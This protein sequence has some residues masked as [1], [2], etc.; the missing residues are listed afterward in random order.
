MTSILLGRKVYRILALLTLMS[1]WTS[2][3]AQFGAYERH[4]EILVNTSY[5]SASDPIYFPGNQNASPIITQHARNGSESAIIS[6]GN[7]FTELILDYTP[8]LDF[9]GMDTVVVEVTVGGIPILSNIYY[10]QFV[11][12]VLPSIVS[13]NEDY[14]TVLKGSQDNALAVLANDSSTSPGL[15]VSFLP[16]RMGGQTTV[17]NDSLF[18]TPHASFSGMAYLSYTACD[19]IGTCATEVVNIC[20]VDTVTAPVYDTIYLNTGITDPLTLFLP[21]SNFYATIVPGDGS[22]NFL[23]GTDA[24]IYTPGMNS[25]ND[26]FEVSDG[27][28]FRYYVVDVIDEYANSFVFDDHYAV[29][30]GDRIEFNVESND[31]TSNF[32]IDGFTQP[33]Y[34][35]L[36]QLNDGRFMYVADT[37]YEGITTFDY[38][39]CAI[40]NCETAT[41]EIT[42][43]RFKPVATSATHHLTGL[44]NRDLIINYDIPVGEYEFDEVVLPV[45]G[46]LTIKEG[47]DTIDQGCVTS[48]GRFMMIYT[49]DSG[50]D[51]F[52][53]FKVS[54]CSGGECN[55]VLITVE[56]LNIPVYDTCK[57]QDQ[58]VWPG[59]VDFN[60][61]VDMADLLDLGN[62]IG[63]EGYDRPNPNTLWYGQYGEDWDMN[64]RSRNLADAKHC[65]TDGNGLVA[66]SDTVALSTYFGNYHTLV[67]DEQVTIKPYAVGL[68]HDLINP[69]DS[70][71]TIRIYLTIGNSQVP[72]ENLTGVALDVSFDP[73]TVDTSYT[74]ISPV[75]ENWITREGMPLFMKRDDGLTHQ[76]G[77]TRIDGHSKVG[78]GRVFA[79]DIIIDDDLDGIR[80]SSGQS[81]R[82]DIFVH[83]V[84][85]TNAEGERFVMP[86]QQLSLDL[87]KANI[88]G[89]RKIYGLK[90]F[91]NPVENVLHLDVGDERA[92]SI[93]IS[94]L[95]GRI[96]KNHPINPG[97]SISLD[98]LNTGIYIIEVKTDKA[99]RATKFIK[100]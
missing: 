21:S 99:V 12:N 83:N 37:S 94:D 40:Q 59:D 98:Q 77:L 62:A 4:G 71:D 50:F 65:D 42:A 10:A 5:N 19:S 91:P 95:S 23:G 64:G 74:R 25:G 70:G 58:C 93:L 3:Q 89:D 16:A 24:V 60:G 92:Q 53:E 33:D 84:R 54:Y 75:S 22:L 100:S 11:I 28:V 97:S 66:I 61:M 78:Y 39:V 72:A 69:P 29:V 56:I 6:T 79:I 51:G 45:S 7:N 81:P 15:Y 86:D 8:D 96:L 57:C 35:V 52:D 76:L 38:T 87:S 43:S 34:G 32:L 49:P 47:L 80:Y 48:I 88:A 20:V 63:E 73:N 44:I 14:Y 90:V 85:A 30:P 67:P 55:E 9:V 17:S 18:F 2:I 1:L 82:L 41:V 36:T 68:D 27:S 26:N 13:T 46:E 31:R